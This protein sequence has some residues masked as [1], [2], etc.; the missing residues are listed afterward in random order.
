MRGITCLTI[1]ITRATQL[2]GTQDLMVFAMQIFLVKG[3]SKS[4]LTKVQEIIPEKRPINYRLYWHAGKGEAKKLRLNTGN[5]LQPK[6][7]NFNLQLH[8]L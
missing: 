4:Y 7:N 8:Y 3:I 1:Q 2:D 6:A 5:G